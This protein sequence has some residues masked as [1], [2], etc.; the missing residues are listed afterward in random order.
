MEQQHQ[1]RAMDFLQGLHDNFSVVRSQILLMEPFSSIQRIYNLVRQEEK[2]QEINIRSVPTIEFAALQVSKQHRP[3]GK[4]Q[5][6]FCDHCNR[7][8]TL[9]QHVITYMVSLIIKEKQVLLH[10]TLLSHQL[11]HS[12]L[13]PHLFPVL[14]VLKSLM[15]NSINYL[16]SLPKKTLLPLRPS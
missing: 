2:Q 1:D 13:M 16:L 14:Q 11:L 6:P 3:S 5:R 4:R 8:G 10:F 12:T 9:G 7:H 15:S